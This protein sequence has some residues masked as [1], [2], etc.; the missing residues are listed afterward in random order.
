MVLKYFIVY[1][2]TEVAIYGKL[3][4]QT[5]KDTW[6]LCKARG[7][8][9]LINDNL[10]GNVLTIGVLAVGCLAGTVT[11]LVSSLI[12]KIELV[13]NIIFTVIALFIGLMVFSVVAQIINSGVATTFV[14][15]CEDP[16]AFRQTKLELWEK[17]SDTYPDIYKS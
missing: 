10:I 14:C 13:A 12:F 17:V 9:A 1:T 11:F 2:F 6:T 16:D 4:C 7:I 15:L 8:E 3:Y 5:A